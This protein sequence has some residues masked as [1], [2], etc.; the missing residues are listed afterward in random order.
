MKKERTVEEQNLY[1]RWSGIKRR[2]LNKNSPAYKNYGGRGIKIC[3]EWKNSFESFCSWAITNGYKKELSI[4]RIDVDGNYEP[5]NCRW[6]DSSIQ[7]YNQ[8]TFK[9]SSDYSGISWHKRNRLYS[10]KLSDVHLGC[11]KYLKD[12][13]EARILAEAIKY[14]ESKTLRQLLNNTVIKEHDSVI[15]ERELV[16]R[17]TIDTNGIP[18]RIKYKNLY[19]QYTMIKHKAKSL[20][21]GMWDKWDTFYEFMN[22]ALDNGYELGNYVNRINVT[23]GFYP[24]NCSIDAERKTECKSRRNPVSEMNKKIIVAYKNI[25]DRCYNKKNKDYCRYG[26]RGVYMCDRWLNSMDDF[27]NDLKEEYKNVYEK[28]GKAMILRKD[29]SKGFS[30]DNCYCGHSTAKYK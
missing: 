6:A 24:S 1:S 15:E 19:S 10:A 13:V 26:L 4:D 5:S 18:Y 25:K 14:G 17:Y 8:R 12:A 30:P 23:A 29:K 2:C 3:D 11:F 9:H 22:W 16:D 28:Y 21:V 20:G 27:C 7:S